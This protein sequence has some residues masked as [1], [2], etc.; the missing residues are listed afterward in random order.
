M[1]YKKYL[2]GYAFCFS[3]F[4]VLLTIFPTA[5][6]INTPPVFNSIKIEPQNPT[7][8]QPLVCTVEVSDVD[9]NLNYVDFKWYRNG[10]PVRESSK[11]VYGVNDVAF[12][13]LDIQKEVWDYIICEAKVYDFDKTFSRTTYA[14]RIGNLVTN[15]APSVT[16]VDITPKHP[17]PQQD[18]TCSILAI[19][20]DDNLDHVIFEWYKNDRLVRSAAKRIEGSSDTAYDVLS[21]SY[22][23]PND[24]VKCKV[25]AYDKYQAKDTK[26]SLP[27]LIVGESPYQPYYPYVSKPIAMISVDDTN[28]EVNEIIR[29]SGY[30]SYDP[31]GGTIR[32]YLFDFG[33]GSQSGWLPAA[34]PYAYHAYRSEGTYYAR[35]KVIDDEG[36][37]SDW[38]IAISISVG[39]VGGDHSP[40]IDD[41]SLK[42]QAYTGYV[43]FICEVEVY[44]KDGDLDYVRFKWYLN[45]ELIDTY[46]QAV[47]GYN[48]EASDSINLLVS[49]D[50]V[51]KCE[52]IVYD[53]NHNKASAIRSTSG[54]AV[55]KVCDLMVKKFDYYSY[56]F[57]G[58]IAWVETEVEN[59]GDSSQTLYLKLYVDG[60]LKDQYTKYLKPGEKTTKKFEFSL[61]VGSHTINIEAYF[62][63]SRK[64]NKT[65][66]ITIFP[67]S[68]SAFIPY[69]SNVSQPTGEISVSINPK[70]LDIEI[71][72][73][74]TIEISI[75]SPV[76]TKFEIFVDG[77]PENWASYPKEVEVE[78]SE[79]FY[80]YIV[81]KE[82]GNYEFKVKVKAGNRTF[83]EHVSLYVSPK[84]EEVSGG[85]FDASGMIAYTQSNWVFGLILVI[86]LI[87]LVAAYFVTGKLK[88]KSYEE[89]IYGAKM[90]SPQN[91]GRYQ[92][93]KTYATSQ[94]SSI[95]NGI[96]LNVKHPSSQVNYNLSQ[97]PKRDGL[98]D[99]YHLTSTPIK[100]RDG[101]PFPK[102]GADFY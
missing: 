55:G 72:S 15:S 33:D 85:I 40:E 56:L 42:K 14:V 11:A 36:Q 86:I 89:R 99:T 95:N 45:D 62:P 53:Q 76:K 18:L 87:A 90:P 101:T 30:G 22:T 8:Y 84:S 26:E 81:P 50:D 83:E 63:C 71:Y 25:T 37:E 2:N 10:I 66:E 17:N 21:A 80:V 102:F 46:K 6:A 78:G 43:Q 97:S 74:D 59:V 93:T 49:D 64:I 23:Y 35:L 77:L 54:Y 92:Q 91:Y 98:H 32:Q 31:D 75:N 5:S 100:Y 34:T 96:T 67:R 24:W 27:V 29:F 19:D 20:T 69:P 28:P 12:D 41:I 39:G 70:S 82:L 44:D 51:V 16:Y 68:S 47:N 73:G 38:S 94:K 79:K 7:K 57:E 48:D 65:A 4:L 1:N 60:V 88:K 3:I 58:S 52:V 61:S 13:T 9:G